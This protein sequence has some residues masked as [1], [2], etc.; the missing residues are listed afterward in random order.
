MKK[1]LFSIMMLCMA[2]T[3]ASAQ[4]TLKAV[5]LSAEAGDDVYLD[6]NLTNA[7]KIRTVEFTL[8]L[9][10]GVTI[11]D[12]GSVKLNDS[13][14]GTGDDHAPLV[15]KLGS[16]DYK[17]LIGSSKNTPFTGNDGVVFSVVINI[18]NTVATGA[19]SI[20][21]KDLLL[22]DSETDAAYET[23][24][25]ESTL[26]ITGV[27]DGKVKLNENSTNP[28]IAQ[29]SVNV[30]VTR[31]IK[32]NSWSTICLPFDCTATKYKA[33][34]GSDVELASISYAAVSAGKITL[35]CSPFT[36]KMVANTPYFIKTSSDVAQFDVDNVTIKLPSDEIAIDINDEEEEN[37]M[38][39]FYGTIK[40]GT[41]IPEDYLFLNSNKFYY[42]KGTTTIKGFRAYVYLKDFTSA[43]SPEID[44]VI[45]GQ[46]T[47]LDELNVV[48]GEGRVYNL[49][50]QHVEKPTEKG[51]YIK[52]GKKFVIK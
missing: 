41:I 7:A 44:L 26:T 39:A 48:D 42:S 2:F 22:T 25:L 31:T 45:D 24:S 29:A 40:A 23:A 51:V 37:V 18:A 13:R 19:H 5:D 33:A 16:G 20:Y 11:D 35:Y 47:K 50:G 46:T 36:G 30:K 12:L 43:S 4:N 28:P 8:Q 27:S 9:P 3:N 49:K 38:G 1:Y 6:F 32:A 52:N 17:F 15:N 34:F 14:L 10:E 21:V